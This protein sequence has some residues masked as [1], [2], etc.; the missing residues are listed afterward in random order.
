MTSFPGARNAYFGELK[1]RL[2]H[3][4]PR[5]R[6]HVACNEQHVALRRVLHFYFYEISKSVR[7]VSGVNVA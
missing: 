7:R 6:Q 3:M 2:H 5:Y 1:T 4:L